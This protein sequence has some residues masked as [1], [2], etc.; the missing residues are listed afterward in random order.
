MANLSTYIIPA[1]FLRASS[2]VRIVSEGRFVMRRELDC[3]LR[4]DCAFGDDRTVNVHGCNW[5][6]IEAD[7][8]RGEPLVVLINGT[9]HT[10]AEKVVKWPYLWNDVVH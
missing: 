5:A 2:V 8:V 7:H 3:E 9:Q 4:C 6:H 1:R 10:L